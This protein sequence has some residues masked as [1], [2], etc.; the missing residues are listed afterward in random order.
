MLSALRNRMSYANVTATLALFFAMSGGALAAS[1]YL[2]TSTKQI[3]PSV[4]SSLRGKAGRAGA[5][6]AAGSAG[7]AGPAGP[8]GPAGSGS[9]G[10]QGSEGK[11][12]TNGASVTSAESK[13][14]VGPCEKG[15]SEFTAANGKTYAC[16]G[17]EGSPWTAGGT[18][19]SA[20]TE[21]GMWSTGKVNAEGGQ[22][23]AHVPISFSIPLA[24]PLLPADEHFVKQGETPLAGSGCFGGSFAHPTAERGNL[25]VYGNKEENVEEVE[26]GGGFISSPAGELMLVR[27]TAVGEADGDWAVTAP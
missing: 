16:N 18:L 10:A 8:T 14:K 25:C 17:K 12:G 23:Y 5:N 1:H 11:A 2:I 19:P 6:G 7:P 22:L 24:A 27:F 15:G 4:L 21:T 20:S 13:A 3:K 9:P 26:L